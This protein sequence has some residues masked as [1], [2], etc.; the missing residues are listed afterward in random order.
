M[1]DLF[2]KPE[3]LPRPVIDVINKFLYSDNDY[4]N[5]AKLVE[6]LE[7]LGYTCEYYLDATPYNLR[8]L[9]DK[10]T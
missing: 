5:C 1:I 7:T 3:V 4:E 2:Y 10:T 9:T 6:E 8:K